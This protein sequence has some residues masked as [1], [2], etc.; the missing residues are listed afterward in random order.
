MGG[1][2]AAPARLAQLYAG[3][4]VSMDKDG[5]IIR[6]F[7]TEPG[8]PV[9]AEATRAGYEKL[10]TAMMTP[11]H[12]GHRGYL[13]SGLISKIQPASLPWSPSFQPHH[14]R[15]FG[16]PDAT[17]ASAV[18]SIPRHTQRRVEQ[19]RVARFGSLVIPAVPKNFGL[20]TSPVNRRPARK[21][22]RKNPPG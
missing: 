4:L 2:L 7:V 13:R 3:T 9:I 11:L 22:Q 10:S 19:R 15:L 14:P 21:K 5:R 17:G 8:L 18:S 16:V 20:K 6:T 1:R 12:R